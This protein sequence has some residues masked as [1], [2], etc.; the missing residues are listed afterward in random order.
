MLYRL[1]RVLSLKEDESTIMAL[2]IRPPGAP[3]KRVQIFYATKRS[4]SIYLPS[5]SRPNPSPPMKISTAVT[6]TKA[7]SR[8]SCLAESRRSQIAISTVMVMTASCSF[9]VNTEEIILSAILSI[10]IHNSIVKCPC[11]LVLLIST[12]G[13]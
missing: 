11:Q 6:R 5:L 7:S 13:T 12:E 1:S 8:E 10:M 4:P 9:I 2:D 3:V